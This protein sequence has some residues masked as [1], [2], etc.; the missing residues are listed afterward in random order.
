MGTA[1]M[2]FAIL[3]FTPASSAVKKQRRERRKGMT[4]RVH[5]STTTGKGDSGLCRDARCGV[6]R[7]WAGYGHAWARAGEL[8]QLGFFLFLLFSLF[9]I[10]FSI[11]YSTS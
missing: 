10:S 6:G 9:L 1:M 2:T 4:G 5:M 11:F 3:G 7:C 8:G